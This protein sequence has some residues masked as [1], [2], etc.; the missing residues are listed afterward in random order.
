M[1]QGL[2]T[3]T[4]TQ[5]PTTSET[6]LGGDLK[7]PKGVQ[8]ILGM[9]VT[10]TQ[11]NQDAALACMGKVTMKSSDLALFNC[12]FLAPP[13]PAVLA[14]GGVTP[15]SK[16]WPLFVPTTGGEDIGL[17][18]TM[19]VDGTNDPWMSCDVYISD[20]QPLFPQRK[21]KVGSVGT[22]SGTGTTTNDTALSINGGTVL[23]SVYGNAI[24][25]GALAAD[26]PIIVRADVISADLLPPFPINWV[27]PC[28]GG[29]LSTTGGNTTAPL[30]EKDVSIGMAQ[31]VALKCTTVAS[32]SVSNGIKTQLGFVYV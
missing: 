1:A 9:E 30:E 8:Q 12:D 4:P 22:L 19:T 23:E 24:H 27:L 31:S 11:E 5:L 32:V 17:F 26:S 13:I 16:F 3:A 2:M 25:V 10:L 15:Y 28:T 20:E 7:L 21:G 6:Q 14:T 29:I 18:G